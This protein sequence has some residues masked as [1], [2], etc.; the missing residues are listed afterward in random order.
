VRLPTSLLWP[1]LV[2]ALSLTATAWLWRHEI[3]VQDRNLRSSFDFGLRQTATRIDAR[4]ASYEQMLLGVRGLF[5]A[6]D[7]VTR[8]DF[9]RYIDALAAGAEFAGLRSVAY[10]PLQTPRPGE[11]H[12]PV[13]YAAPTSDN[14]V[15][16][17]GDDQFADPVRRAA[18]LQSLDSGAVVITQRLMIPGAPKSGGDSGFLLFAP[19]YAKNQPRA[20][21]EQ[22][23]A[24]AIG[25]VCASFRF[26]DVVSSLYGEGTP[27]LDVR[28]HDGVEISDATRLYPT[29]LGAD[30]QRQPR[31]QAQ[32]YIGFAG[33]SWTVSVRSSPAFEQ[34]FSSDTARVIAIAGG[35]LS[36]L[37]ALLAWQLVTG[38]ERAHAA[39]RAMTRQLRDSSERYRNIVDTAAEGIWMVDATGRTSFV[40]PK[41]QRLLGRSQADLLGSRWTDFMDDA[42]RRALEPAPAAGLADPFA[43]Q[44]ADHLDVRFLRQD[45]SDLWASLSTSPI[46]D[47]AGRHAGTLAMVTDITDRHL[48]EARRAQLEAQLRQSQKMEAIGTLAGGVAHDFNNILAA[49]LGNL[50]LVLQELQQSPM[51]DA[52]AA[53]LAQ[54][55]SAAERG[56][57]L[58]QQIVAFSRQQPQERSAQALQP[59]LEEAA[60]LLRA[61]LPAL[62]EL[63]LQVGGPP[64]LV[65]ANATQLQ[66]VLM[67]LCT[68]AWHAMG[69]RAGRIVITL[70]TAQLDAAAGERVG[71]LAAGNYAHLRVSD[72]GSGMDE[73]TRLRIFE[74]FYTTKPVGQGTGLGLAVVHGIVKSHGGAITVDSAPG[75]GSS[76]DMFFPLARPAAA[77]PAPLSPAAAPPRGHG[78]GQGQGQ[79]QHVL[80]VDD[81]PVMG[82]MVDGLLRRAGYRVSCVEGAREALALAL[83]PAGSAAAVDLVVSD[84]NMP[85]M[86]G[87][88]LA[89][90]LARER[91]ALP[92]VI[93]SG[94][95]T[96]SLRA[97]AR[98]AGVR[99]V[100]QKEYT[101]DRLAALVAQAIAEAESGAVVDKAPTPLG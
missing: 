39:A 25:W 85:E 3:E 79:G 75:R 94:Y 61:T 56:R 7:D 81:D 2:G 10:V 41:M 60:R 55:R 100:L 16:A 91:P 44:R 47:E 19:L 74:P 99:H 80:Y 11:R 29:E 4:V 38:R 21:V 26:S 66:Q 51:G 65:Q 95:V 31:L 42:G 22:R 54:I 58:V 27:G 46:L 59:L 32:E 92:V 49:I 98:Q 33:H 15:G 76:F 24:G 13:T 20:T 5:E 45:G 67:N 57:S 72:D 77:E 50:D 30:G 37:L 63:E 64:L 14:I 18:M 40:N 9:N 68:N 8:E 84:F 71:G 101:L 34:T 12:A 89:R 88:D 36:L 35:G 82:A 90:A 52:A 97:E 70:Q 73:A 96:D 69:G 1:V 17:L 86:S 62:V 6:S 87:L 48:A 23:R 78:S 53:R 28:I 43:D 93:S 83:A